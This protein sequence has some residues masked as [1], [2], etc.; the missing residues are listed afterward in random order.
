MFHESLLEWISSWNPEILSGSEQAQRVLVQVTI[1]NICGLKT[2]AYFTPNVPWTW[3]SKRCDID[4][5]LHAHHPWHYDPKSS[6]TTEEK[7]T[8]QDKTLR[9]FHLII[10]TSSKFLGWS[11]SQAPSMDLQVIVRSFVHPVTIQWKT[12][13]LKYNQNTRTT[14]GNRQV[15][16]MP[17]WLQEFVDTCW[18][19]SLSQT[20]MVK[21]NGNSLF[22]IRHHG[23]TD[24]CHVKT[25]VW[26]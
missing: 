25:N 6:L 12:T 18:A 1:F 11:W 7:K 22:Y 8:Y 26:Y 20:E 10:Q 14:D 23:T 2:G 16:A 3:R 5:L 21:L 19:Q 13:K 17:W 9:L 4:C 24:C 15:K